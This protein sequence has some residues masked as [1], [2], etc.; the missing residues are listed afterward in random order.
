MV[1]IDS[2]EFESV[3]GQRRIIGNL[4]SSIE[5]HRLGH[6][7]LFTG[8]QGVGK[9]ALALAMVLGMKCQNQIPGGCGV[10]AICSRIMRLEDPGFHFIQ[11]VPSRPK[12]MKEEK[13]NEILRE[14][15]VLRLQNPYKPVHFAPELN[16]LP[17]IGIE[18]VRSV[19]QESR[20]MLFGGGKRLILIS[21]AEKM[22]VPAANSLL[23]LLEEPPDDTILLLT[24]SVPNQMLST[25]LS[26]CQRLH[27]D[28][29]S[30]ND[31]E[32]AL[33]RRWKIPARRPVF[34]P[35]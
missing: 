32:E 11:P 24:S 10:C 17:V 34:Y 16:T 31:V 7:Y 26:R 19:K 28:M 2:M 30:E 13:Y 33:I 27:L 5:N 18:S 12:S 23:K 8:P 21:Q 4:I 35:E 3:I 22:T 14:R 1:E 6:A 15:A 20:L 25:I 29:L 9:D